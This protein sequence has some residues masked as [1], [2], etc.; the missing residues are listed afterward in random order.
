MGTRLYK[1][2]EATSQGTGAIRDRTSPWKLGGLTPWQL[3]KRVYHGITEDEVLT[4]SAALAYY[5]VFALFLVLGKPFDSTHRPCGPRSSAADGREA[6]RLRSALAG[7][8]G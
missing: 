1:F 2:E 7:V 3:L 6:A 5:F 4:R 8:G